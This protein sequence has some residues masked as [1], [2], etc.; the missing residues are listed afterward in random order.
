MADETVSVKDLRAVL[1][2][3][4]ARGPNYS[5]SFQVGACD[6]V[7]TICD[8][9]KLSPPTDAEIREAGGRNNGG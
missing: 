8:R 9:L 7:V 3:I 5:P 6:A 1:T 2:W 4:L